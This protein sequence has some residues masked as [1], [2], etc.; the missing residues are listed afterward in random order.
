MPFSGRTKLARGPHAARGLKT[1]A[2]NEIWTKKN[3][4]ITRANRRT[5]I[6]SDITVYRVYYV[7]QRLYLYTNYYTFLFDV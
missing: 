3:Q 4:N 7:L 1:P 2:L 6:R 5:S